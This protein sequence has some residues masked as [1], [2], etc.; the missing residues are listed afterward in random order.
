ML[1]LNLPTKYFVELSRQTKLA[2]LVGKSKIYTEIVTKFSIIFGHRKCSYCPGKYVTFVRCNI[3]NNEGKRDELD[4]TS[5]NFVRQLIYCMMEIL[6]IHVDN[7]MVGADESYFFI[8]F[9]CFSSFMSSGV[10][11]PAT[12]ATAAGANSKPKVKQQQTER[13]LPC[14]KRPRRPVGKSQRKRG[15]ARGS[16]KNNERIERKFPKVLPGGCHD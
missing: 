3:N 14:P 15:K 16:R 2:K 6:L 9:S 7:K 12:A 4:E 10:S 5:P 11:A 13:P 1:T 8:E